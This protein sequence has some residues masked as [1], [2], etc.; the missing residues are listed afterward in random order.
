MGMA[1]DLL[2]V[3]ED[4]PPL[5]PLTIEHVDDGETL[6]RWVHAVAVS[7][8]HPESVANALMEIHAHA[9]FGPHLP[10]RL[11]VGLLGEEVVAASRLLVAAG[12]AG[13]SH[14]ATIP[15]AR[16]QGI[17]TAM[18]LAPLLE[19]RSM[20]YRIGVLRAAPG[21]LGVYRRL[22]FKE[23]CRFHEYLWLGERRDVERTDSG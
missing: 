10:W 1:V 7:F 20:G 22:G 23:Y 5:S 21:G 16:R 12:V 9:G 6:R 15:E 14:L 18:T 4:L 19:A 17:G 3:N 8:E 2:A 11:Y 13:I